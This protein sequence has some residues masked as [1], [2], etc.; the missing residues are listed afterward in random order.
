MTELPVEFATLLVIPA[1]RDRRRSG[2]LRRREWINRAVASRRKA[3]DQDDTAR[4]A[5]NAP[6]TA[7]TISKRGNL[8]AESALR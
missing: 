7:Q 4:C 1:E 6:V 5:T 3:D 8:I 2:F